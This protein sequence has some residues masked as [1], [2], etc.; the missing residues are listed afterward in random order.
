V[1]A[2][3]LPRRRTSERRRRVVETPGGRATRRPRGVSGE[4]V[5]EARAPRERGAREP[6]VTYRARGATES[7]TLRAHSRGAGRG[8]RLSRGRRGPTRG[9]RGANVRTNGQTRPENWA[10]SPSSPSPSNPPSPDGFSKTSA[11][12]LVLAARDAPLVPDA[13]T[14]VYLVP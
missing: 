7:H 3:L 12:A 5:S 10:S 1:L 2:V 9:A 14:S 8:P 6:V 13:T 11:P 4:R